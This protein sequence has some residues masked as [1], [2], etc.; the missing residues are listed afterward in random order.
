M[1]VAEKNG[2]RARRSAA[3]ANP[4]EYIAGPP[5]PVKVDLFKVA[6]MQ[7]KEFVAAADLSDPA[8]RHR[9]R[10]MLDA[11]ATIRSTFGSEDEIFAGAKDQIR[12][13]RNGHIYG[14]DEVAFAAGEVEGQNMRMIREFLPVVQTFADTQRGTALAQLARELR[15]AKES[16]DNPALAERLQRNIERISDGG[17]FPVPEPQEDIEDVIAHAKQV[18]DGE[19]VLLAEL[20]VHPYPGE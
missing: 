15:F 10:D 14:G 18:A 9:I 13:R 4:D 20:P 2:T 17:L 6:E 3:T 7:V 16:D 1:T 8:A 12:Q 19:Q 5:A 11:V